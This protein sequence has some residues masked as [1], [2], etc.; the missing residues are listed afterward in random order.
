MNSTG[1]IFLGLLILILA[2]LPFI[3]IGNNNLNKIKANKTGDGQYG[4]ADWA[5]NKEISNNLVVV[6]YNP[7]LWRQKKNLPTKEGVIVGA[8]KGKSMTAYVD[9]SDNHTMIVTSPGGGKTTSL[10]YPNLEYSAACGMSGFVTD[11]KGNVF[12]EYA[13]ILEKYYG[14][15]TFI[16]DLRYPLLSASYNFLYLVNK[17]MDSYKVTGN[18]ADIALAEGYAKNIADNIIHMDGF[19]DAGQ[20][21]FF[22]ASAEGVISGITL[23]VSEYCIPEERHIVSVFKLIRQLMEIDPKTLNKQGV[24]PKLYLTEIYELL[25]NDHTVKDLLAPTATSEFKAMASVMSTAMSQMLKFIDKEMEQMLCFD[26]GFNIDDF[27]KGKSFI[28]FVVD[29]KSNTKNFMVNLIIKQIYGE[30]LK[31]AESYPDICLPH[32]VIQWLDEFGTY[33]KIDGVEQM[34]SAGR[35]RN[36]ITVPF[37]Q[38]LAQLN[39]NYGKDVADTIKNS[40]QNTLFSYQAPTSDD[41]EFFSKKLGTKTVTAG[42]VSIQNNGMRNS[43]SQ[44]LQMVKMP[45][46]SPD[47]IA[48][49]KKGQ[50]VF[51]K[52]GMN[53][54]RMR[55]YKT[56]DWGITFEELKE[57]KPRLN[58]EVKYANRNKLMEALRRRN[59]PDETVAGIH[60]K[61]PI[62]QQI[63]KQRKSQKTINNDFTY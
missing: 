45:I 56:E 61:E 14:C 16:I 9:S 22:Y 62:I 43:T 13:P 36:I 12:K 35:S 42:S 28:F 47:E 3:L 7:K 5:S 25:P 51:M 57:L 41:A 33:T 20:N 21:Q 39:K 63:N 53:P 60:E 17:Y 18:L 55:L 50:W 31:K 48:R 34:F 4:T 40:C 52:A 44:S 1:I 46:M 54:C 30:L 37:L 2:V 23:L 38:T 59:V 29:E 11:T 58:R 27:V 26:D 19:K 8:H 10:L 24:V 32:R 49:L 6:D 15:Q